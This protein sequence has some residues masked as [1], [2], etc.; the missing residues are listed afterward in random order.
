MIGTPAQL[1]AA[2]TVNT[3]AVADA[4]LTL[5]SKLKSLGVILDSRL[6]FDAHVA[7]VCKTCY[8]HI[9]ALR[10]IQRLLPLDMAQTLACSI[11]G[12]RLDY[13]KSVLYGAPITSI[14]KLR[15]V[16]NSLACVVLQ[17]PRMSPARPLLKSLHWLPICQRIAFTVAALTY[18][19]RSIFLVRR[20]CTRCCRTASVNPRIGADFSF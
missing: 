6:S 1:R 16:Q 8:Y 7:M 10:L 15:R 19:I 9:W 4:N 12:A 11:V 2:S 13:C 3:V 14:Q 20:I 5:W 18:K 17:Q